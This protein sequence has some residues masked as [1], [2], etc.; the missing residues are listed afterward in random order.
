LSLRATSGAIDEGTWLTKAWRT[1]SKSF[2]LVVA[3]AG[4]FQ[5]GSAGSDLARGVTF[6]P[7]WVAIGSI[8]NTAQIKLINYSTN[9]IYLASR[10]SWSNGDPVWL[11]RKS[12]GATVLAGSAPD[13]GAF[14]Y[15]APIAM[16]R[17]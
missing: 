10:V 16:G 6:F 4:Y 1:G 17:R 2:A 8:S 12:D 7:D 11:V 9:T 3:D 15:G 5:D 13:L 14:E